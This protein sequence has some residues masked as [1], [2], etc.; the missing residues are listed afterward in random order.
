MEER[1]AERYRELADS[2]EV[3]CNPDT[4]EAFHDLAAGEDRH[5]ADFPATVGPRPE[6]VP[7]GE[8]DPEIADPD[9][10]HYLM[11]PWHAADLALRHE[12]ETLALFTTLAEK[13]PFAEVRAEAAK[14]VERETRHVAEMLAKRDALPT[15][16][17]DWYVD[18]DGPNWEAG[19]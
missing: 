5:A 9:A 1:S 8:E 6:T 13:S 16:P 10:V 17:R 4:A 14:L 2:F 19:D 18:E 15:P 11:H 12:Q 3:A 7:W